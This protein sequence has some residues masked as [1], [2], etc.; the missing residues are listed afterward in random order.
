MGLAALLLGVGLAQTLPTL[1]PDAPLR[2]IKTERFT[3]IYPA[4]AEADAQRAANVLSQVAGPVEASLGEHPSPL[5]VVLNNQY[6]LSNGFVTLAPRHSGWWT[7]PIPTSAPD[8]FGTTVPWIDALA[9]HEYRHVAQL[10]HA[11][12]GTTAVLS[13]MGGQAG[14][15]L[16]SFVAWPSWFWEGDA[17][18]IETALT[19]GGR[20]RTPGYWMGLR[21]QLL[22]D[23]V[24]SYYTALTGSFKKDVPNHYVLGTAMVAYG[25]ARYDPDL[26]TRV[27]ADAARWSFVPYRFATATRRETGMG[28]ADLHHL[29]MIDLRRR[30]AAE[31]EARG[32]TLQP[33]PLHTPPSAPI[34]ERWTSPQPLADGSVIAW[35]SGSQDAGS[36][37][38]VWPDGR[39]ERL[40]RT[41]VRASDRIAAAGHRVIWDETRPDPRYTQKSW[42]VLVELDLDTGEVRDLTEKTRYFSPTLSPDGAEVAVVEV[43]RAGESAVVLLDA[44]TGARRRVIPAPDRAGLAGLRWATDAHA[45]DLVIRAREGGVALGRLDLARGQIEAITAVRHVLVS[46]P[47]EVGGVVYYVSGEAGVEDLW[48][49]DLASGERFWVGPSAFGAIAP[50]ARPG[51]GALVFGDVHFY[52]HTLSELPI[53]RASWRPADAAPRFADPNLDRVIDAENPAQ[54]DVLTGVPDTVY[55]SEPYRRIAHALNVHSWAPVTDG[56]LND[57]GVSWTISDVTDTSAGSLALWYDLPERTVGGEAGYSWQATPVILDLKG[58]WGGRSVAFASGDATSAGPTLSWRELGVQPGLRLPLSAARGPIT[59]AAELGIYA[60]VTRFTEPSSVD[61]LADP[62]A[63]LTE[64]GV[65][66]PSAA[67]DLV[68][69]GGSL[70]LS[71]RTLMAS[72]EFLPRFSQSLVVGAE[73]ALAVGDATGWF[74]SASGELTVPGLGPLHRLSVGLGVEG[75]QTDGY[76]FGTAFQWPRG[77]LY[78]PHALLAR[79][80]VDY[81][82]PLLYPDLAFG[83]VAYLKRVRGGVFYDHGLG[84]DAGAATTYRSVGAELDLDLSLMRLPV[85]LGLGV[86]GAWLIDARAP[87]LLPVF[88]GTF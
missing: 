73:R 69:L 60:R 1:P 28:L 79:G 7:V 66:G 13:I 83:P 46:D 65:A 72:R 42:S 71:R 82:F 40:A 49:L 18:V 20:M 68:V 35:R 86:Q 33:R 16:S 24:P 21:A 23:G 15:Q 75:Q 44:E 43:D 19:Q 67:G 70:S 4:D 61:G 38:R 30:W 9:V 5:K 36:I 12:V 56:G 84:L 37:Q 57:L 77:Y 64:A 25:R 54:R 87:A 59:R 76:A 81:R 22:E 74:A 80:G 50:A 45:I 47:C 29:A 85:A 3:I 31:A 17:V 51:G 48:A 11:R 8:V 78:T 55:P 6:T 14:W 63:A 27:T 39:T 52:G 53:D 41:G 2:Q 88:S 34:Y 26:W 62:D 32:P 58:S 10:D